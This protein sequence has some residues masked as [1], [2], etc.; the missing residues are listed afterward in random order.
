MLDG[1][2]T[3][4]RK[5]RALVGQVIGAPLPLGLR[6]WDGSQDGPQDGAVVVLRNRRAARW[7][8]WSPNELGLTRAYVTGDLDIEGDVYEAAEAFLT[9]TDVPGGPPSPTLRRRLGFL[10]EAIRIGIIGPPPP[11]PPEEARPPRRL[12]PHSPRRDAVAVSHHYD[13]GNDFYRLVLGSSM[14]YSCAYWTS[15]DPAYTLEDAQRDKLDL[16]S[17]KL[18]LGPGMR[19][20]DVGCGWGS[21]VIHA[22]REHGVEATGITVSQAQAD[23]ARERVAEE[24]LEHLVEIR[25]QDYRDVRDGPY[26][27]ICSIGM[28]EHVGREHQG[29]YA[30]HLFALLRPQGRLLHH[31]IGAR[32][33]PRIG[34]RGLIDTYVFPDGELV[35]IGNTVSTLESAGF[36]VRDLQALREHYSRTLRAWVFRLEDRWVQAVALIGERRART[37]RLYMVG[38]AVAFDTGRT[39][40]DQV[41]AVRSDSGRSG[42]PIVREQWLPG[43]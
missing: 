33:D 37:W 41:V 42:M 38:A 35:R 40:V 4:A 2:Q 3:T 1:R 18:S 14:V 7:L 13:V 30:E 19:L 34:A 36:E 43:P 29:A 27:A 24:G 26:D 32:R 10:W 22:A 15:A 25:V 5:L 9:L 6:A 21:M 39:G 8:V 28:A 17:R 11:A 20:L 16:V 23:L 12:H 31:A